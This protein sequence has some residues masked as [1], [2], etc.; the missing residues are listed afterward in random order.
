MIGMNAQHRDIGARVTADD[1]RGQAR[2]VG[3]R[4]GNGLG[5]VDDVVVGD[6]GAVAVDDEAGAR[7]LDDLLMLWRH[8][9]AGR[10][11]H[12]VERKRQWKGHSVLRLRTAL[13]AATTIIA[14]LLA[15]PA[16]VA[17]TLVTAVID[18][19]AGRQIGQDRHHGRL[20][21]GGKL[22]KIGQNLGGNAG[23]QLAHII[24]GRAR[25]GEA[26]I[27]EG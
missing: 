1:G 19:G 12:H 2:P 5:A 8:L 15:A 21:P 13:I 6:D 3:Q 16:L 23:G 22:C 7:G 26:G 18:G 17:A 4:H 24:G 20:H 11:G 14:L 10:P 27:G 25:I 9:H